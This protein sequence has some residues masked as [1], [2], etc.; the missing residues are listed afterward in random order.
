MAMASFS[1]A[2][3]GYGHAEEHHHRLI[4]PYHIFIVE[5]PNTPADLGL[6]NGCDFLSTISR[7]VESKPLRSFGSKMSRN[8]GASVGSVVKAQMVMESVASNLSSC[9]MTTGR[10]LPA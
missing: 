10:G 6:G 5:T 9:T 8:N 7:H 1:S 4:E 2:P 3:G